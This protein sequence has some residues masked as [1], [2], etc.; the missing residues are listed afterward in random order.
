MSKEVDFKV[1]LNPT[2]FTIIMFWAMFAPVVCSILFY[3]LGLEEG[4]AQIANLCWTMR[5][6]THDKDNTRYLFECNKVQ[7]RPISPW[8]N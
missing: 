1:K 2:I 7:E 6:F 3:G 5:G 4:K 8:E